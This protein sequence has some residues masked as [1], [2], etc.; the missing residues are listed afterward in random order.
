MEE[1]GIL[2]FELEAMD[3]E[4]LAVT[5]DLDILKAID[6]INLFIAKIPEHVK[7]LFF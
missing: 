4:D 1:V 3:H 7:K 2:A 6:R 5:I